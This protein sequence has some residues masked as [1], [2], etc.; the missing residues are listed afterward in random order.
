MW[1]N[2]TFNQPLTRVQVAYNITLTVKHNIVNIG[3]LIDLEL[4][5]I[6]LF[7]MEGETQAGSRIPVKIGW[8][9]STLTTVPSLQPL[10][11]C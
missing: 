4:R 9:A 1:E 7:F 2:L 8:E 6:V 5:I 10:C 11:R 3:F